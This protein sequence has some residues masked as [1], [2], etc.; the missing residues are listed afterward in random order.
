MAEVLTDNDDII[1]EADITIVDAPQADEAPAAVV[2]PPDDDDDP[3]DARLGDSDDP[4]DDAETKR[5]RRQE[6]RERQKQA[7]LRTE[8]ELQEL[9]TLVPQL[10][11]EV[12]ELRGSYTSSAQSALEQQL[13]QAEDDARVALELHAQAVDA[14]NGADAAKALAI[15]EQAM[16]R[17]AELR[18]SVAPASTAAQPQVGQPNPEALRLS[19][20]WMTSNPWFKADSQD[21]A[22]ML[23]RAIDKQVAAEGYNPG[24]AAYWQELTRRVTAALDD[25][26]LVQ[27]QSTRKPPTEPPPTGMGR[28][29]APASTKKGVHL[30]AERVQAI[31]DAGK[32]DDPVARTRMIKA[33]QDYDRANGSLNRG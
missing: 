28:Q 18:T 17:A 24:S 4:E 8:A 9:R 16:Q 7:R 6:R 19:Q 22:S 10:V 13:R 26:G 27:N 11:K 33:F 14:G 2:E 3:E 21:P 5:K 29:H 31:K 20:Q 30:S 1:D 15:R 12:A 23:T 32:W 25:A